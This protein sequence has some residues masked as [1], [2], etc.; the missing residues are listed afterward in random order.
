[1]A[2]GRLPGGELAVSKQR[3]RRIVVDGALYRWR[4]RCLDPHWVS[5]RVWRDGQRVPFADVRIRFDD[6]CLLSLEMAAVSRDMPERFDELF[7]CEPVRP[8][9]V[10]RLIRECAS[11]AG[12][13]REFELANGASE[14][15]APT[16]KPSA[17]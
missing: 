7:T 16:A 2:F 8:E 1:M 15:A 4:V 6:P 17:H 3:V 13:I 9:H 11:Q 14:T 10:A 5:V 12:T